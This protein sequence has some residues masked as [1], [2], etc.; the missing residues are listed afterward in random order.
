MGSH[1]TISNK[2][3]LGKLCYPDKLLIRL[4]H[5]Y[6][7]KSYFHLEFRKPTVCS[8][9]STSFPKSYYLNTNNMSA[10]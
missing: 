8:W 7:S 4:Y 9:A 5:M 10:K 6:L 2:I 1:T 3:S